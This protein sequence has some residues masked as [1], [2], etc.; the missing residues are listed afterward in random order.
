MRVTD[1]V[2]DGVGVNGDVAVGGMVGGGVNDVADGA[3]SKKSD[4]VRLAVSLFGSSASDLF[5]K[6]SIRVAS[7]SVNCLA[8]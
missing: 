7:A 3:T 6:E 8:R 2:I 1:G 4:R 5:S